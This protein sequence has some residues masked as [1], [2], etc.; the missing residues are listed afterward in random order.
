MIL[1]SLH[2][3]SLPPLGSSENQQKKKSFLPFLVPKIIRIIFIVIC[4]LHG[5][6]LHCMNILGY[7]ASISVLKYW[8]WCGMAM[9]L[10]KEKHIYLWI[11]SIKP[12]WWI[13]PKS[14][15]HLTKIHIRK[16]RIDGSGECVIQ[17]RKNGYDEIRWNLRRKKTPKNV[18]PLNIREWGGIIKRF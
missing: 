9:K 18:H 15:V 7:F 10:F 3:R 8:Y 4:I 12:F 16:C 14:F 6:C 13:H 11:W 17:A 2:F 5:T 1:T